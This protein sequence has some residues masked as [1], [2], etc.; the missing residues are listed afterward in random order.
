M[1]LSHNLS[2]V[3]G[4]QGDSSNTLTLKDAIQVSGEQFCTIRKPR[5]EAILDASSRM[6]DQ[7]KAKGFIGEWMTYLF[8]WSML[9]FFP[10]M[11]NKSIMSYSV[12]K[13]VEKVVK[14][15]AKG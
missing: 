8:M 11:L 6:S 7:K 12:E 9:T 5:V 10:N 4:P 3:D 13:E 2:K 14:K 1:L 15:N